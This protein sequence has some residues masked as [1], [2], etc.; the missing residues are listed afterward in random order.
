MHALAECLGSGSD[1]V[2]VNF[3]ERLIADG[4][5]EDYALEGVALIARHQLH[6]HHLALA[7]SHISEHLHRRRGALNPEHQNNGFLTP[8]A[9]KVVK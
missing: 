9:E 2:V 7:H 5:L 6:T 4:S 3:P 8:P 1:P